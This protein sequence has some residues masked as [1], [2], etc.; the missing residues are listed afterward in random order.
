MKKIHL[1]TKI[2]FHIS[3]M[4]LI[5]LYLYPGSILGW[6]IYSDFRKQP[7]LTNDFLDVSS[8]HIYAFII[9]SLLGLISFN[10][11]N[12]NFLFMYLFSISLILELLQN[13]I[14]KRSFE[15]PDLFGNFLGVSLIFLLY[16]LYRFFKAH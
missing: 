3:N 10:N 4:A 7:Q 1:L 15:Y 11:K 12:V 2:I 6:L 5:I 14:P 13:F 9:I 8:S 16:K